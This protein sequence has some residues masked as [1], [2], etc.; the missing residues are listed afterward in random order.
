[1]QMGTNRV[2][3]IRHRIGNRTNTAPDTVYN[4]IDDIRTPPPSG[5]RKTRNIVHRISQ[6]VPDGIIDSGNRTP[7]PGPHG[8]KSTGNCILNPV[9]HRRNRIPDPIPY[10]RNHR[11]DPIHHCGDNCSDS[12]P[13]C[14]QKRPDRSDHGRS[15]CFDSIPYRCKK[16]RNCIPHR[17]NRSTDSIPRS[18][19]ERRNRSYNCCKQRPDSVPQTGKEIP[20]PVP[21][22]H[23]RIPD[24]IPCRNKELRNS[25]PNLDSHLF[26]LIPQPNPEL[27]ELLVSIPKINKRRHK[28]GNGS[29]Y[30]GNGI[31]H[32]RGA[33][34]GKSTLYRI[35]CT[36][37][38]RNPC[39]NG[40]HCGNCLS[41]QNQ[42]RSQCSHQQGNDH[43]HPLHSVRH[44]IQHIHHPLQSGNNTPHRRHQ[45]IPER[46]RQFLKL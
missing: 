9:Y 21:Y 3:H 31:R 41:D 8:V 42:H 44:G 45:Q 22:S 15:N 36:R 12:I 16:C 24:S 11:P 38:L 1:M 30:N 37:Q 7:D 43:D 27:P 17:H 34:S 39:H 25:R 35:D 18:C 26:D 32:H 14:L 6:P 19:K 40:S 20:D 13:R 2:R 23:R 10:R 46:N 4:T 33:Q 5:R 29:N 28:G